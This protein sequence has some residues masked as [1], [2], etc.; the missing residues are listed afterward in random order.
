[1]KIYRDRIETPVGALSLVS[2]DK[3]LAFVGLKDGRGKAADAYI[4]KNFPGAEAKVGGKVNRQA[5]G[6]V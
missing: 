4:A 6:I 2:T 1:M 5:A 3:G